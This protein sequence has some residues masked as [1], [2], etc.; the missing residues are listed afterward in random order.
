MKLFLDDVRPTPVGWIPVRN[1]DDF[2]SVMRSHEWDEVSLDHD[3]G[4]AHTLGLPSPEVTGYD[5]AVWMFDTGHLPKQKPRVHSANPAGAAR[6]RAL[7]D[8]RWR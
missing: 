1:A 6:M 3:L 5:L 4:I 2:K 7:I 8:E